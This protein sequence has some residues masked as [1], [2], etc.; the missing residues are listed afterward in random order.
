MAFE[1]SSPSNSGTG[2]PSGSM[3]TEK[4]PSGKEKGLLSNRALRSWKDLKVNED[5]R[6]F[7]IQPYHYQRENWES[8]IILNKNSGN[9]KKVNKKIKGWRA[10]EF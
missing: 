10:F 7:M 8:K 2:F 9:I 4:C 6:G 5:F 3:G 1:K